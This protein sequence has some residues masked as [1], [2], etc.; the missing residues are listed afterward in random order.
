LQQ[1]RGKFLIVIDN[2]RAHLAKKTRYKV[3]KLGIIWLPHPPI[4][5]SAIVH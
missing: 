4:L 5:T 2:V 1:Y 3:E